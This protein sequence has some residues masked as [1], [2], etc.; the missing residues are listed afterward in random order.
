M[1]KSTRFQPS[2][3]SMACRVAPSTAVGVLPH[4]VAAAHDAMGSGGRVQPLDT[5][6]PETGGSSPIIIGPTNPPITLP[7]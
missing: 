6:M 1:R 4:L 2:L 5:D 3:E 7:C